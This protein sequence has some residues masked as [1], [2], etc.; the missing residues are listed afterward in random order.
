[1]FKKAGIGSIS[2]QIERS[3]LSNLPESLSKMRPEEGS[4]EFGNL[5]KRSD[6]EHCVFNGLWKQKPKLCHFKKDEEVK[7]QRH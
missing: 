6:P 4:T 5:M 3:V 7:M 2:R 1:M